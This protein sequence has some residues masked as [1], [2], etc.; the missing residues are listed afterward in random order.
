MTDVFAHL[1]YAS[2]TVNLVKCEFGHATVTHLGKQV[3]KGQVRLIEAKVSAI[4][5]FPVANKES[6]AAFSRFG[7]IILKLLPKFF[8]CDSLL[9]RPA[10]SKTKFCV[11]LG[12]S[13]SLQK[14]QV[15]SL[16]FSCACCTQPLAPFQIRS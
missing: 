2:L 16:P 9:N 1:A 6:V 3:G 4:M 13:R 14:C 15:A 8:N 10:Q 12:L 5:N 11:V 7:G